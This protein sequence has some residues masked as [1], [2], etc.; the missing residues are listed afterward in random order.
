MEHTILFGNGLQRACTDDFEW[1]KTLEK[2]VSPSHKI[3]LCKMVPYPHVFED[4]LLNN[5]SESTKNQTNVER[6]AKKL[7]QEIAYQVSELIEKY[8]DGVKGMLEELLKLQATHYL[9]TN[10]DE[11]LSSVLSEEYKEVKKHQ[12]ETY[13]NLRR[14]RT[15]KKDGDF[16]TVW[17]I[18][19]VLQRPCT[20][21]LGYQHY[22]NSV[23]YISSYIQ[24]G[25]I[26]GSSINK[27][28]KRFLEDL[29]GEDYLQKRM[30]YLQKQ[31]SPLSIEC[32]IDTFFVTNVH[33]IALGLSFDEIDIW[34]VLNRWKIYNSESSKPKNRISFY[35]DPNIPTTL[36]LES[37][38]VNICRL[39]RGNL[40]W[41]DYYLKLIEIINKN[42]NEH[43]TKN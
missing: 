39:K 38:G 4:I 33:I 1:G 40:S 14:H 15:Y 3:I 20:I 30:Q 27:D 36:M 7:K 25:K 12:D 16:K 22:C 10:Y 19:G 11:I 41:K 42:I 28:T 18:H 5:K 32:W 17:N 29:K 43:E 37:Y 9:T 13:Y 31:N 8:R 26:H 35:G 34:F 6:K 24:T 23:S 21:M 2:C